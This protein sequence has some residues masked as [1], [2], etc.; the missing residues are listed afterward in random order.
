MSGFVGN[1]VALWDSASKTPQNPV[2]P[3]LAGVS[4][5][6]MPGRLRD[7]TRT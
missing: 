3:K 5:E 6:S 4:D 2:P 1:R 7:R